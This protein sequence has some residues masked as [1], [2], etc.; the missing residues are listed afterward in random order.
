MIITHNDHFLIIVTAQQLMHTYLS[1]QA[2]S[3]LPWMNPSLLLSQSR[4]SLPFHD[5]TCRCLNSFPCRWLGFAIFSLACPDLAADKSLLTLNTYTSH[6]YT[7]QLIQYI[8]VKTTQCTSQ[9]L[10]IY[11]FLL[12]LLK[13]PAGPESFCRA[14]LWLQGQPPHFQGKTW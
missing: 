13:R 9:Q 4:L 8:L 1:D 11:T 3:A 6:R 12:F 2:L 7:S 14:Q 10:Y 5:M